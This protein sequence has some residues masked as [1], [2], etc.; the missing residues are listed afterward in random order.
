MFLSSHL[1]ADLQDTLWEKF[2]ELR[3]I[4]MLENLPSLHPKSNLK[5][6]YGANAFPLANPCTPK[7]YKEGNMRMLSL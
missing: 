6:F 4:W 1:E 2:S 5:L 3:Q 7:K